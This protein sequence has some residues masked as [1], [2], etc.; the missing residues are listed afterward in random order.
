MNQTKK[1]NLQSERAESYKLSNVILRA[2]PS[3][4]VSEI[5]GEKAQGPH[6]PPSRRGLLGHPP[7]PKVVAESD[8]TLLCP[9]GVW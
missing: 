5:T 1:R 8:P 6:A 3:R 4:L 7:E 2:S 9:L